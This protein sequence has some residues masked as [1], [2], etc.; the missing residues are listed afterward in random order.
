[1]GW[2]VGWR[3][4]SVELASDLRRRVDREGSTSCARAVE[5]MFWR[6]LFFVIVIV[7]VDQS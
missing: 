2:M 3:P 4:L 6:L 7:I 1:M 5:L